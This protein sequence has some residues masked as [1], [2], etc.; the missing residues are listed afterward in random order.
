MQKKKSNEL[1][2]NKCSKHQKYLS[3]ICITCKMDIC[4]ECEK[5]HAHHYMIKQE[6][7]K[8][9]EEEIKTLEFGI[10]NYISDSTELL[11]EIKRWQKDIHEKILL[12]ESSMKNNLILNS[13]DFINTF[14]YL[15]ISLNSTIKF[16]KIYSMIIEPN[17]KSKNNKVLS[18]L[19]E[20]NYI[21]KQK[22]AFESNNNYNL[23]YNLNYEYN[24]YLEMKHLLKEINILKDN[25]IKKITKIFK[26]LIKVI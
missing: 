24:D 25:Y 14:R 2:Y 3:K 21:S 7:I 20:D 17:A 1:N 11:N 12:F 8:P 6:E 26:Y 18:F 23:N 16:R 4:S 9:E 10:Q 13:V 22:N 5:D 15:N 19:N